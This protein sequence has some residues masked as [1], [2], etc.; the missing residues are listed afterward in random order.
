MYFFEA[1][2][3]DDNDTVRVINQHTSERVLLK[4][5]KKR[6]VDISFESLKSNRIACVDSEGTL[7]V[8]EISNGKNKV[9]YPFQL[10]CV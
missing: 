4:G 7:Y 1:K 8:Y 9:E 3:A 5:F 6:V 10:Y 2:S